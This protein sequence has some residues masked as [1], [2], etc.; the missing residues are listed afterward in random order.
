MNKNEAYIAMK[1]GHK[2][3]TQYFTSNEYLHVVNGK[4]TTEDGYIMTNFWNE[5]YQKDIKWFKVS[6]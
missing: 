2:V 4:I 3:A 5:D 1:Q 6:K